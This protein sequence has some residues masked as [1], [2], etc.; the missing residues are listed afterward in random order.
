MRM[1]KAHLVKN[2]DP[3]HD[4]L[5]ALRVYKMAIY[6]GKTESANMNILL[7]SALL[8]DVEGCSKLS[9][10]SDKNKNI[11]R[12]ILEECGIS[13]ET[14]DRIC[15][16]IAKHSYSKGMQAVTLEEKILQDADR[17]D[18]LGAIGIARLFSVAGHLGRPLYSLRDPFCKK[19][20]PCDIKYALDHFYSKILKLRSVLH[21]E[22]ARDLCISRTSFVEMFIDQINDE[23][24]NK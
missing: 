1:C 10:D 12:N 23:I 17:L 14:I 19:R 20:K 8:H 9:N 6:L 16:T 22:A 11:T 2:A 3:S 4:W 15:E 18:A 5:H 21:T 24:C 13:E 7:P